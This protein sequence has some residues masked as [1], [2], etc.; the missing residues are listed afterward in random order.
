[1]LKWHLSS[2][3]SYYFSQKVF[4]MSAKQEDDIEKSILTGEIRLIKKDPFYG[5]LDPRLL[6]GRARVMSLIASGASMDT[7]IH[8][9]KECWDWLVF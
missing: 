1:M 7:T 2:S 9:C 8:R 5:C 3:M 6:M 4:T